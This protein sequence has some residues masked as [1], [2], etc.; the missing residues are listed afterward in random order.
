MTLCT[1]KF[2]DNGLSEGA[3]NAANTYERHFEEYALIFTK[4]FVLSL[5]H[6]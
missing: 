6:V 3:Q 1:H 5:L 4:D 2:I